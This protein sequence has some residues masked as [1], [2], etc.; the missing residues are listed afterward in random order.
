VFG[1]QIDVGAMY[2]IFVGDRWHAEKV[3]NWVKKLCM[4]MLLSS[5]E[6]LWELSGLLL[7]TWMVW[8]CNCGYIYSDNR[9]GIIMVPCFTIVSNDT[10]VWVSGSK[11]RTWD[12]AGS[13]NLTRITCIWL[14]LGYP[15]MLA[16][17]I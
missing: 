5:V 14:G 1:H 15:L 2:L 17:F 16:A 11:K 13:Q 8:T 4:H 12:T 3:W 9:L 7:L 10:L 6:I